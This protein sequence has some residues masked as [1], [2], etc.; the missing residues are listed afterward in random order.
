[1]SRGRRVHERYA[2]ELPVRVT[3]P[4]GES[5]G[6]T[7]NMSLGGALIEVPDTIAFGA[8]VSVR[9]F[10]P[11]LKEEATLQGV[12][13]WVK[14]SAVGLQWGSLRAKEVWA[15]NQLFKEAPLA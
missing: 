4:G 6:T 13:R 1:M 8:T 14:G 15:L 2:I 9:V 3:H 10:L 7:K 11:P 12:V 5:R